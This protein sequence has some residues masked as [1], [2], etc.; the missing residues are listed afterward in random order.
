MPITDVDTIAPCG[1]NPTILVGVSTV[2]VLPTPVVTN[3]VVT[4]ELAVSLTN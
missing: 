1:R 3:A 2:A 4:V